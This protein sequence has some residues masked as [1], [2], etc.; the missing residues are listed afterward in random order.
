MEKKIKIL[1]R[2]CCPQTEN[3][4][5]MESIKNN[6]IWNN[7][8]NMI[9]PYSL[10]RILS[11]ENTEIT[12]YRDIKVEDAKYI[13][14]NYDCF[15]IPLANAFRTTFMTNLIV[16][17]QLVRQLK[18]PCIVIGVGLQDKTNPTFDTKYPFD[19]LVK[20]FCSEILKRSSSIGVRGNI[21]KKYLL[22]LGFSEDKIDVI[23]C[24]SMY[25]Y[26]KKIE[27]NKK[28]KLDN[29]SKIA[30][31]GHAGIPTKIFDFFKTIDNEF[32]EY[33]FI[34]QELHELKLLYAGV[35]FNAPEKYMCSN[36]QDSNYINDHCRMFVNVPS[37]INFLKTTDFSVGCRIHGN[38]V[39]TLAGTPSFILAPDSRVQELAEFH[40]L[41]YMLAQDFNPNL[42]IQDLYKMA[43]YETFEKK[44]SEN[45]DLFINF[46][47]KNNLDY[48]FKYGNKSKFD[49]VIKKIEF[50]DPVKPLFS[51]SIEEAAKRLK[52]Y[53]EWNNSKNEKNIS[54]LKNKLEN[55]QKE[56][57]ELKHKARN[58]EKL[59]AELRQKE[60]ENENYISKMK[61]TMT[62]YEKEILE[63]KKIIKNQ[64]KK[65]S[66]KSVR[67]GLGIHNTLVKFKKK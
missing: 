25:M 6:Y 27:I 35:G 19:D 8:G 36:P 29:K 18:I 30:F 14:E 56:S 20:E 26:G 50:T 55:S 5:V 51:V 47:E 11:T 16:L 10:F 7:I 53:N 31:N 13:N 33:Y 59:I 23:G 38:I 12:A 44:Q 37:W 54:S 28:E 32:Q 61:E 39:A 62:K 9:F 40:G 2:S 66:Y 49:D 1:M 34:P 24:P 64:A 45:F 41:P 21:T 46:L 57:T 67:L 17:T 65:L 43:N 4:S 58:N 42:T 48:I 15:I 22:N 60:N 63:Q 3:F 52:L